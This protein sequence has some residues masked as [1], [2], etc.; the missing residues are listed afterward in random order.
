MAKI[1][2]EFATVEKVGNGFVTLVEEFQRE[3]GSRGKQYF[4]AWTQSTAKAGD[5]VHCTGLMS[6]KPSV[7]F[8]TGLERKWTDRQGKEHTSVEVNVNNATITVVA[9]QQSKENAPF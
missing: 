6:A 7:D 3:D 4:K 9:Q 2:V 5:I 8:A 1:V